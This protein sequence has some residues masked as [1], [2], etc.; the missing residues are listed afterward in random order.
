[1]YRKEPHASQPFQSAIAL[2]NSQKYRDAA[3]E[4]R[5]IANSE[6]D[7]AP[8]KF[9]LGISLLLAGDHIAGIEVL[10]DLTDSGDSPYLQRARFYLAKALIGEHDLRR[11][12]E[13]LQAIVARHGDLEKQALALLSEI[14]PS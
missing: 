12:Q 14:K 11:A 6:P 4:F 2:Y 8:A 13:Q 10:R 5:T 1:M 3:A 7:F 9:Y